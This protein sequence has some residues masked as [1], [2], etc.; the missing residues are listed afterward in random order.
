MWTWLHFKSWKVSVAYFGRWKSQRNN[1]IASCRYYGE[2]QNI[3]H[4]IGSWSLRN[5]KV[6]ICRIHIMWAAI[7]PSN[8]LI[9]NLKWQGTRVNISTNWGF[10]NVYSYLLILFCCEGSLI[11]KGLIGVALELIFRKI[12]V[13]LW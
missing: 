7:W 9:E 11:V 3:L 10:C 1:Q 4:H 12:C 5:W 2:G 6:I 13:R 8:D